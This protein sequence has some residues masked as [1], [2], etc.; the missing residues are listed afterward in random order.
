M[1]LTI[2]CSGCR[3]AICRWQGTDNCLYD[4]KQPCSQCHGSGRIV[5]NY[6][7]RKCYK[8]IDDSY[9]CEGFYQKEKA[10]SAATETD[11]K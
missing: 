7:N 6:G 11:Q 9:N 1:L 2:H 4:T 10:A 8:F 5:D 3:C